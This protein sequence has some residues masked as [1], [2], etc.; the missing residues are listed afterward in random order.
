M[1]HKAHVLVH[2]QSDSFLG[3]DICAPY[4]LRVLSVS[5][6]E[7]HHP[8]TQQ[9]FSGWCQCSPNRGNVAIVQGLGQLIKLNTHAHLTC[10]CLYLERGK[11][12]GGGG[13]GGGGEGIN[14]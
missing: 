6:K 2:T 14:A 3:L 9:L 5:P 8:A 7:V 11:G 10:Q 13:G 4:P 12:G 1:R